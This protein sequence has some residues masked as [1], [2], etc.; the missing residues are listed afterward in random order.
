MNSRN[1]YGLTLI[2]L[3]IGLSVLAVLISLAVPPLGARLLRQ[4]LITTAELMAADLS[5]ARFLAAQRGRPVFVQTQGDDPWCWSVS[6]V[7]DCP[8]LEALTCQVH[9]ASGSDHPGVA[10]QRAGSVRL[11]AD[12]SAL[13]QGSVGVLATARG[14]LLRVDVSPLGRPRVCSVGVAVSRYPM[15]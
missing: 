2:E 5:E 14:E 6:M 3:V 4:R 10:L 12:G 8:C 15:C 11:E 9:R 1:T 13:G 7:P